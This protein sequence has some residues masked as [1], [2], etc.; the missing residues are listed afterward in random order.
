MLYSIV[1]ILAVF[2]T[3][4]ALSSSILSPRKVQNRGAY[5]QEINESGSSIVSLRISEA[6]GTLSNPNKTP[7]GGNGP[8]GLIAISQDSVVVSGNV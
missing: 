4:I 7:T 2:N 8:N 5:F 3:G 6:D 1:L